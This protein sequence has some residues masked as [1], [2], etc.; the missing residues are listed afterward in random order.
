[1]FCSC[2][3]K[4]NVS[5]KVFGYWVCT[6]LNTQNYKQGLP[7]H[8]AYFRT[9]PRR[10]SDIRR[11]RTDVRGFGLHA[12]SANSWKIK[13]TKYLAFSER[14]NIITHRREGNVLTSVCHSVHNRLHG[15]SVTAHPCYS[16]VGTHPM[17]SC[18]LTWCPVNANV[19]WYHRTRKSLSW[20]LKKLACLC[21]RE[22]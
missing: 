5:V 19:W 21:I 2:A 1:M 20:K 15:Y 8:V 13:K 9:S 11:H 18:I 22:T 10:S 14:W 6:R 7:W 17:L 3:G 12:K 16:M 4:D